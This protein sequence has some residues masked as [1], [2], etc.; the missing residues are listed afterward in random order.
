MY[1]I[2]I[3]QGRICPDQLDK[4]QVYPTQ[5]WQQ[6]FCAAKKIGF[7]Y[8]ELLYGRDE[9][10]INP[11]VN[12]S[13]LDGIS[14]VISQNDFKIHSICAD[15]FTK[16]NFIED[17][18]SMTWA[19]LIGLLDS[20]VK[21]KA[22][23][24]IVPFFDR[25]F[26]SDPGYLKCFLEKSKDCVRNSCDNRVEICIETSS[27]A[28][29]MLEAINETGSD[30]KVCYDL[31]NAAALGYD[32]REEIASLG[33]RI[34]LVHIKDRIKNGGPNVPLGQGDVD[35]ELSFQALKEINYN[36]DFTLETAIGQQPEENAKKHYE[37]AS[38]LI[39]EIL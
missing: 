30:V 5:N 34:A 39:R 7:G 37:F 29:E 32:V 10:A 31:G 22:K 14:E 17:S 12:T 28:K 2:G 25:N 21:L 1:D 3:M 27:S 36:G 13:C 26:S 20:S 35:F 18:D 33:D 38:E 16:V 19:K 8:I 9:S 11:L 15:Y 24:L 4:L 6:E 23:F